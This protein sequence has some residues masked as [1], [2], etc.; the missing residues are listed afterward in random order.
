M[1]TILTIFISLVF[2]FSSFAQDI[3]EKTEKD[4]FALSYTFT[5]NVKNERKMQDNIYLRNVEIY[6]TNV[7]E[8]VMKYDFLCMKFEIKGPND[9]MYIK[10]VAYI[11]DEISFLVDD[12]GKII[13]IIKPANMDERWIKA[14]EEILLD[15]TGK[16]ITN[17]L[18]QVDE[19]IE[20]KE[21]LMAFF[22]SD[23]MYGLFLKGMSEIENP[24][25]S[26]K[27]K[28][29][30]KVGVKIITP[31]AESKEE[32]EQYTFNDNILNY[33][34]KTVGNIKYE[35]NFLKQIN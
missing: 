5:S 15:F 6:R 18:K 21:K 9:V 26:S 8:K 4:S 11:F 30:E 31:K 7:T 29:S 32:T 33:A 14:K 27:I 20:D 24:S 22:Q 13:D 23:N 1:K 16:A 25:E 28:I 19:A 3:T 35:I 10:K 17:F 12:N 34:I 2:C